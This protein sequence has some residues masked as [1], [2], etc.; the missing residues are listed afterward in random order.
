[1]KVS[2]EKNS[3]EKQRVF[4]FGETFMTAEMLTQYKNSVL[5]FE[6]L[7]TMRWNTAEYEHGQKW[8]EVTNS[9]H[10]F[11]CFIRLNRHGLQYCWDFR[12]YPN[13]VEVIWVTNLT[14]ARDLPKKD[15]NIVLIFCCWKVF[16][17]YIPIL[18]Y[19]SKLWWCSSKL[20]FAA[21]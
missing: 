4:Y 18:L 21:M 20:L 1:M 7:E 12:S 9:K 13:L 5:T 17:I 15:F 6:T 3:K 11:V 10:E 8:R 2:Y 14:V 16:D 19:N